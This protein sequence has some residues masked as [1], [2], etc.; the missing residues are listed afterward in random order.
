[1]PWGPVKD[2]ELIDLDHIM[3]FSKKFQQRPIFCRTKSKCPPRSHGLLQPYLKTH[4][5]HHFWLYFS[6]CF[7]SEI[8][9]QT[10]SPRYAFPTYNQRWIFKSLLLIYKTL[11]C[12]HSDLI[13]SIFLCSQMSHHRN[14]I[15]EYLSLTKWYL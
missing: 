14:I 6:I 13:L 10:Y 15:L 4:F 1:M 9:P 11:W 8:Q 2:L 12:L 5:Q 3:Y 7:M